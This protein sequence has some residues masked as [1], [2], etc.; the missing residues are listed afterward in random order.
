MN[1]RTQLFRR[2]LASGAFIA[3]AGLAVLTA[4]ARGQSLGSAENFAV[5]GASTVTQ[6]WCDRYQR[7]RGCEP[8]PSIIGFPPGIV[9]NGALHAADGPATAAHADFATAYTAFAGLA[10][11]AANNLT[12]QDL[13]GKTLTPGVYRFNT[14]ATSNGMLTF[15]AQG[16][17]EARFVVQ[18]GTTLITSGD[19]SVALING[20]EARNVF[21]QVGTSATLGSGSQFT[22]NILAYAAITAV[23][24]TN[25]VGR[26]LALTEAV[27]MDANRVIA[28]LPC[29]A[30]P[31][32]MISWWAAEDNGNDLLG[33]NLAVLQNGA[34]Y[35]TEGQVDKAFAFSNL[36]NEGKGEQYAAV[37]APVGL[38]L[39]NSARTIEFWFKTAVDFST[40]TEAALVQYGSET[41][42]NLFGLVTSMNAPGKLSFSANNNDLAGTTTLQAGTWYHAAVTYDGTNVMLYLNGVLETSKLTTS[43]NTMLDQ[44]GLTFGR[45]PGVSTWNGE[46]D[47]I[48]I[49]GRSL[50][51]PEIQAIYAAGELGKCRPE[52]ELAA[53]ASRKFHGNAGAFDIALPA[54]GEPGV[55]CRTGG[56]SGVYTLVYTFS[57]SIVSA[58][59][60]MLSGGFVEGA[61]FDGLTMTLHLAN[62]K[63]V[64]KITVNVSDATDAVGQVFPALATRMNVLVGD[65]TG[66]RT[67]NSSDMGQTKSQSGLNADAGNFRNDV[68]ANGMINSSDIGQIRANSGN[69]LD[70]VP[71]AA[72]FAPSENGAIAAFRSSENGPQYD[73]A[74]HVETRA[75]FSRNPLPQRRATRAD[76]IPLAAVRLRPGRGRSLGQA[77][78]AECDCPPVTA[79]DARG[80]VG[81]EV[82]RDLLAT[83][84]PL[85][86]QIYATQSARH[87]QSDSPGHFAQLPDL[88]IAHIR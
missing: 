22:G 28:P 70:G 83:R 69:T 24:G 51:Q 63:D 58:K 9:M 54:I 86:C 60:Q 46:L 53:V 80:S 15:D 75:L 79:R 35:T 52:L 81:S 42:N 61:T 41:P 27:T 1:N 17:P 87:V 4:P 47:E 8:W 32:G 25:V 62:V 85:D 55:E 10:S 18:I 12:D 21:F 74:G 20:A 57:N 13:G 78:K 38:P 34:G 50:S 73:E 33:S 39:G 29:T 23:G 48:A 6:H 66:N 67:V 19:S 11:P 72:Q 71:P 77:R 88:D 65:T 84:R 76:A 49:Y 7:Q 64:Q 30:P 3:V 59:A 14:A 26:L 37:A 40:L 31:A 68:T 5:L 43:L 44:N 16:D 82:E 2:G 36:N 45:R 56:A